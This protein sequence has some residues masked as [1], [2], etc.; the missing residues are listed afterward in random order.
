VIPRV[1]I[2][3]QRYVNH[4]ALKVRQYVSIFDIRVK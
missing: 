2:R 1:S 3:L 4:A